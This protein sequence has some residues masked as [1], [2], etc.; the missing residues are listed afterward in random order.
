MLSVRRKTHLSLTID[1]WPDLQSAEFANV[2]FHSTTRYPSTLLKNLKM[3]TSRSLIS[4]TS[5]LPA[6]SSSGSATAKRAKPS[7]SSVVSRSTGSK[8]KRSSSSAGVA[9]SSSSRS[10]LSSS[11]CASCGRSGLRR[12]EVTRTFGRGVLLLVVE[13]IPM[14]SCPHCGESYFTAQTLHEIERIKALRKSVAVDRSIPVAV[15]HESHA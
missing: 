13:K 6:K 8:P 4:K 10:I 9:I 14:W 7:L 2:F 3:T 5:S 15:F 12:R 1:E 11:H